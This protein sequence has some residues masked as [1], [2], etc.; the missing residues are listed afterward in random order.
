MEV[1]YGINFCVDSFFMDS[2]VIKHY[3]ECG[4]RLFNITFLKE[5]YL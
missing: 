3:Q 2:R 1:V 4:K 5:Y